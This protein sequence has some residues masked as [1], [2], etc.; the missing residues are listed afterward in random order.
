[1]NEPTNLGEKQMED[2]QQQVD[3]L[4]RL[5]TNLTEAAT[6]TRDKELSWVYALEGNRDGVWDWNAITNEV[7]FSKR[8]K[9]MLGFEE[10][11]IANDL[12]EWDKRVHPDD[13]EAVYA[14]LNAHLEGNTPYYENEHRVQCK[15]GLYIWIL[16]RGKILSWTEAGKPLRVVGTHSDI[17]K[18]KEAEQE[19]A[20][21]VGELRGAL[22]NVKV[23]SGLLPICASCKR[24]RDDKG[25]WGQIESYITKHS[26][27]E[28]SHGYCPDCDE[29]HTADF[30]ATS[31]G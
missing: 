1:M 21:L 19:N 22:A 4:K 2:L 17:T 15:N 18:R 27:A 13:K 11:E 31:K 30:I 26:E 25:Y 23:L 29:K 20:R 10:D 24:I 5:A 8:W 7:F 28:F 12:S 6:I 9:E 3:D 16:D 14:D